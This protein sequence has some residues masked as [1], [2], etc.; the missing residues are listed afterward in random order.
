MFLA[1]MIIGKSMM[2]QG[3]NKLAIFLETVNW[4]FIIPK[5]TFLVGD[6]DFRDGTCKQIRVTCIRL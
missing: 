5:K 6:T 4:Y 3:F 2:S 1:Y